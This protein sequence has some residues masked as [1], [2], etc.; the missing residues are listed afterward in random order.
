[1]SVCQTTFESLDVKFIFAH[2]VYVHGL[3]VEFEY[4]G[5]QVK[6]KVTGR[7]NV[8]N[9]ENSYSRNVKLHSAITPVLS[10]IRRRAVMFACSIGFSGTANRMT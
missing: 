6:V 7:R 10:N 5:H 4:E 9:V 1:M 8:K 3:Q 2:E